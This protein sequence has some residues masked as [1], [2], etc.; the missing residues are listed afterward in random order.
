M[1]SIRNQNAQT[2]MRHLKN[3]FKKYS[4]VQRLEGKKNKYFYRN[5]VYNEFKY[6]LSPNTLIEQ[7]RWSINT[8]P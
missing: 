1:L 2:D 4:N 7:P 5:E 6:Y 8:I 3:K